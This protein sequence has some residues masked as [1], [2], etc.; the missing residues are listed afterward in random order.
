MKAQISILSIVGL[1]SCF[2]IAG[3]STP[4]NADYDYYGD[5]LSR[6]HRIASDVDEWI[7]RGEC[8]NHRK[9]TL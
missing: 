5:R 2:V 6:E 8:D 9:S 7:E 4:V 1:I 3:L